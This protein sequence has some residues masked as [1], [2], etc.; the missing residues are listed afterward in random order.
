MTQFPN[1]YS[2]HSIKVMEGLDAVRKRPGMY[3][4]STDSKGLHHLVYEVVDNSVDEA[5]GGHCDKILIKLLKDGSCSIEDNGRGIP[6]GIHPTEGVSAAEVVL[7]KLHAG[8]KFDKESYSFSGGLHGVGVSVVNALSKWLIVNIYQNGNV[9]EQHFNFGKPIDSLKIIGTT[10]KRGTYIKFLPDSEIFKQTTEFNFEVLAKRFQ[11]ITYLNKGLSI[12]II[13]EENNKYALYKYDEGI[14][15]FVK[16]LFEEKEALLQEVIYHKHIEKDFELEFA[17]QYN[18]G[19][20]EKLISFVNNINTYEGGTHV[21]GFK[22]ALTA[23]CNKK[24]KELK[25]ND[26]F[27]SEDVREGLV[28]VLSIKV[29]EPQFE[30]Q[31]KAKLGNF[32]IKG[33]VQSIIGSFLDRYFEENP[34]VIKKILSKA[35]MA[36]KAREA[37][38]KARELTRKKSILDSTVLPGK[39]A[40]CSLDDPSITEIFIVEG[41]SAGGSAKT[42]RE[43]ANQAIL[44]L[45][46]KILNVEKASM[47]KILANEEIK[48]L[49]A[50]IGAGL[51]NETI[52]IQ[53]TRYHKIIIMT[54]ADVDGSHIRT[55]LLT[56]F[57]RYLKPVIEAGYIYIAQPPLY[58]AKIGKHDQYL[59]N[60]Q[61]LISFIISWA[62]DEI[63]I[64]IDGILLSISEKINLLNNLDATNLILTKLSKKEGLPEFEI[65]K[66]ILLKTT[67]EIE[68]DELYQ[69]FNIIKKSIKK[70]DNL[71]FIY[72]NKIVANITDNSIFELGN[73]IKAT[74]KPFMNIQRYKGLGEMNPE[75]LWE[76][77]M[78]PDTRQ[79]LRVTIE[80]AIEA[81]R[82]FSVLMGED[83]THRKTFIEERS[84]FV[85]N[86]DI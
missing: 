48:S 57:F 17:M 69:E 84:H 33:V 56:L 28:S 52:R 59:Q 34:S 43:R 79:L 31:T 60:D 6:T 13:D 16:N 29:A 53:D 86:L 15:S 21:S 20:D 25:K 71:E 64:K 47:E 44:P 5:L 12:E 61:E 62:K 35:E 45:R 32:D 51:G 23:S 65:E 11:E 63:E 67:E 82:W 78:N 80:D 58:K 39:L 73:S 40:D 18:S 54:D 27:S 8:G 9:Y 55:L 26:I 36:L 49:V 85:R 24:G 41:D 76:T 3:I 72:K 70:W 1:E 75:Q 74:A 4:G 10:E 22:S 30:G 77:A 38:K 50:A 81:E 14:V 19:Y 68:S 46:G 7:T 83:V 37:A 42:A 2:A 66:N